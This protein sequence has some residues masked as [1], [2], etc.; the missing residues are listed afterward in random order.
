MGS[1]AYGPR[2][3]PAVKSVADDIGNAVSNF[4]DTAAHGFNAA[5]SNCSCSPQPA[6]NSAEESSKNNN[7]SHQ[8][9]STEQGRDAQGKFTS[10]QPGQSA[11]GSAAEKKGLDSVGAVKNTEKLNGTVRDGTIPETG[12][13]VEVKSGASVNNTQ[14]LQKMGKAAMEAT[15]KPLKVVT[16]NP[17]V[18]VSGKA[19]ANKTLEFDHQ[20]QK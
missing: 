10:K 3:L 19:Q 20:P 13:H 9:S 15:G 11:P 7:N 12:Q 1:G 4:F 8:Q 18:K 14:Q 17:N 5:Y 16:T 2:V 6:Q